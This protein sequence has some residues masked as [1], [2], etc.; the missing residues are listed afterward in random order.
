M[1]NAAAVGVSAAGGAGTAVSPSPPGGVPR[2]WWSTQLSERSARRQQRKTTSSQSQA[3]MP[4]ATELGTSRSSTARDPPKL[5]T[6]ASHPTQSAFQTLPD[7]ASASPPR[8]GSQRDSGVLKKG[9]WPQRQGQGD[10]PKALSPATQNPRRRTAPPNPNSPCANSY[11][12]VC[13]AYPLSSRRRRPPLPAPG[14]GNVHR[15]R[16]PTVTGQ[17]APHEKDPP[18]SGGQMAA[19][20]FTSTGTAPTPVGMP[21]P[22]WPLP[23]C[24]RARQ[25]LMLAVAIW[26]RLDRL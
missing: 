11:I 9:P 3:E 24:E 1:G 10:N 6:S 14:A 23:R 20:T 17:S 18:R 13:G 12:A 26:R 19:K 4:A 8:R 5:S 22:T 2:S 16:H 7:D 15:M 21:W 25:A